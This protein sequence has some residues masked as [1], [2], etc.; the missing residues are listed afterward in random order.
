MPDE[1]L[2]R[3]YL[4]GDEQALTTLTERYG[5]SL[6]L[7]L[8][9]FTHNLQDAEDLMIEAFARIIKKRPEIGDGCFKSYLYR[10]GRNLATN[11]FHRNRHSGNFSLE[12]PEELA[13]RLTGLRLEHEDLSAALADVSVER[14]F[15]GLSGEDLRSL[16]ES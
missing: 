2:Y 14:Y 10:T 16:L 6:T 11:F 8:C 3:A 5:D 12:E 7:Y 4:A 15:T 1:T 13:A 9:G